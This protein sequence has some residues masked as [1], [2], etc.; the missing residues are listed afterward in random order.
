MKELLNNF[1]Y[2]KRLGQ[3][4]IFDNNLLEGIVADSNIN[5]DDTIVEI[6][7]GSGTLTKALS[8]IAKRVVSFEVDYDL[9]PILEQSLKGIDNIEVV[10][11]NILKLD[12]KDFFD[13][14]N[15]EFKV[16][17]NIPYYITT[18]II[19][20]FLES[21]L[22][23]KSLTLM[24]QEEVAKR[25]VAKPNTSDF[26]AITLSVLL[27]GDVSIKR[28]INRFS[29]KPV[30]KVDSS[31]V[32][33]EIN[34]NKYNPINKVHLKR[35]IRAGFQMRRKT[36]ANNIVQ[37]FMEITKHNVNKM[38]D[39]LG[40]EINVRGEALSIEDYIKISNYMVEQKIN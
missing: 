22:P 37:N 30:P 16:V 7:T 21:D 20:Y 14:I 4:F 26:G 33:I 15:E 5:C 40:Y 10:F 28:K 29:F 32:H 11:K 23:F 18:P 19:M 3:N 1:R 34:R 39:E 17:A 6:G 13:I 27:E 2:K 12:H 31:V 35:L 8:T 38:L 25:L 36:F 9:L 24:V